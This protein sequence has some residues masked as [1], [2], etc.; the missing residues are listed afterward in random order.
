MHAT[1]SLATIAAAAAVLLG[2][3]PS[4]ARNAIQVE[5]ALPGTTAWQAPVAPP[6]EIEGYASEVS[7]R[8]GGAIALHVSAS[9][10][11]DY[12]VIVYRLGW[13]AGKGARLIACL[14]GCS[15]SE[16]GDPQ[17]IPQPDPET[18]EIRA[19]WPETD[20]IR[21][22]R[23]W[24]TGYYLAELVLTSG[25]D[26][27]KVYQ[28]P[29]VVRALPGRETPILVQVPVNTWQAY[30]DWGGK[31]LYHSTSGAR[32]FSDRAYKVSFDRPYAEPTRYWPLTWEYPL[33]RFLERNGYDVS[34]T[35]D[36]DTDRDP[37]E[38]ERHR[39]V[40]VPGHSEYWTNVMRTAFE[41]ARAHDINLAFFGADNVDWQSRY[42]DGRRTLVVYKDASADPDPD[43][44]QKTIQFRNLDPPRP[45]CELVGVE[46]TWA[47]TSENY[48]V[49]DSSLHDRWFRGTGFTRGATLEGLVGYEWDAALPGCPSEPLTVFFHYQGPSGVISNGDCTRYTAPSGA[50]V[51]AAGSLQFSWGLDTFSAPAGSTPDP[52]LQRFVR[53]A[54]ADLTDRRARS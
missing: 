23:T 43:P 19:N 54:I 39:L 31:S 13:Y 6:H 52:R 37:G 30:N 35:T 41:R 49:V 16:Q 33:V 2:A 40:I 9:P 14:P 32:L 36:V 10:A 7:A 17:P 20:L 26:S 4:N 3:T 5:N 48:T 29:F 44:A 15:A 22:G 18:G 50:R 27:G 42:E 47:G 8:P 12:R 45:E 28:V 21:I 38:I 51:F 34:Y 53:N 1:R 11:A 24:T 46:N 25:S